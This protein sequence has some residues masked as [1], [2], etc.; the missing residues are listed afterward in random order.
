MGI[1]DD[2][3]LE[4]ESY[5]TTAESNLITLQESIRNMQTT[6]A[7]LREKLNKAKINLDFIYEKLIE[8]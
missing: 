1:I 5:I 4:L 8:E 2:R 7:N 3:K 6:E